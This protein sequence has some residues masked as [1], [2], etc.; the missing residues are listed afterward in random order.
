MGLT[1]TITKSR[2]PG[3]RRERV[4]TVLFDSSYPTGGEPFDANAVLGLG[5]IDYMIV[6]SQNGYTF[7]Y[8]SSAKKLKAYASGGT[9]VADT[10]NLST[11]TATVIAVGI[12][13]R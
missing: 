11:I 5:T 6:L 13:N 3:N 9:E 2:V 10:T 12:P 1:N 7:T 8:D 4:A